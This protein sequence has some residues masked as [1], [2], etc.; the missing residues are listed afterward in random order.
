MF[1]LYIFDWSGTVSDDRRPVYEA[2]MRVL[3]AYGKPVMPFGKW[4]AV[5]AASAVEFMKSRG[6]TAAASELFDL[7]RTH[8]ALIKQSGLPPQVYPDAV[9]IF[10]A[11]HQRGK[12]TAVVST[13]PEEEI[14]EEAARYGITPGLIRGN[15]AEKA[16]ALKEVMQYFGCTRAETIFIGDTI[17]DIRA[18]KEASI[19][20]GAVGCGYHSAQ[21]LQREAPDYFG[22]T[23]TDVIRGIEAL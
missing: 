21:A 7:Y 10:E 5:S 13:H 6:V 11:L 14:R 23:L 12:S 19:R 1:R 2:N 4:L 18:A 20:S 8:Y 3:Q 9:A 22:H 15:L 17:Y 16:A